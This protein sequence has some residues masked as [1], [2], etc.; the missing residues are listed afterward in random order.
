MDSLTQATLG[1]AIGEA[2]LGKKIGN[3]AII[4]GALFGTIPDLDIIFTPLL[5]NAQ[6]LAF[7]RGGSHSLLIMVI[8]SLA[9]AKPLSNLWKAEKVSP[10]RAGTF[11]FLNWLT[12]VLI[13]CFTV[14]GTSVLWPFSPARIGLN[15]LFII[16][17][18]YT[19]PLLISLIWL[20][21]Y[22]SKKEQPKRTRIL[23]WGLG[24]ST[25]YVIFSFAMKFYASSSFDA[26]LAL[27][28]IEYIRRMEAPT[29]F[30]T[31]LWRSV[32]E[33]EDEIWVGYHSVLESPSK[34]I[35]WT[36]YPRQKE[37]VAPLASER[38]VLTLD[39][40]SQGWWIARPHAQGIWIADMR[41]GET[42]IYNEKPGMVDS[43]FMFSWSFEPKKEGERISYTRP[44]AR[45]AKETLKRIGQRILG[46]T[47]AWE[48]NPRLA[49]MP[50][51]LPENL[52]VVE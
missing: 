50:G 48:A 20:V 12:H 26:D 22:R 18:L 3:R 46:N 8:A 33:R 45:N 27:R 44:S 1:A 30:N 21:F 51:T 14:Y 11:I 25:G 15:N 29:A 38:E 24:L 42:R 36:V 35:R 28:N 39:W 37:I 43:R 13:D 19:G 7:H 17:P 40:F 49:G 5:D 47:K 9:L 4:W 52:R 32:V 34:P 6:D 10:M 31:L 23:N 16:D 2:I 41:F